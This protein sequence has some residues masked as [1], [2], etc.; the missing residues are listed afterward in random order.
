M[1]KNNEPVSDCQEQKY[2]PDLFSI[3]PSGKFVAG[4]SDSE[5]EII[6]TKSQPQRPGGSGDGNKRNHSQIDFL[7]GLCGFVAVVPSFF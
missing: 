2:Q 6:F 5:Y 1:T 7:G 4:S 3:F